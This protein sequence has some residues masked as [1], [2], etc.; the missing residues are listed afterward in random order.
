[1]HERLLEKHHRESGAALQAMVEDAHRRTLALVGGLSEEQLMGPRLPTV[2]P[3]RWE[4]GH[5][6]HFYATFVLRELGDLRPVPPGRDEL[7]DS[8]VVDHED[9]W[10]LALPSTKDTLRYKQEVKSRVLER[11]PG[12]PDPVAT[13]LCL[14]GVQHEDM[15]DEAFLMTRQTLEYPTPALARERDPQAATAG[16]LPGDA[17]VPGGRLVLG[18]APELPFVFDNEKWGHAVE[19]SPFRIA[20]APVTNREFAGFVEDRGYERRELWSYQG[21]RWRTQAGAAHPAYWRRADGGW[22]ARHFDVWRALLPDAPVVH[23]CWYEAEAY[24]RWAGRRLPSELEWEVAAAGE[25]RAAGL[26]SRRRRFPWGDEEPTPERANLDGWWGGLLDVAA[27]PE[28]QS[29]FG[30]R[31]MLGNV[32]EWTASP[33]YPYPGFVVDYPYR[34]YSAPWFGYQKVLRGG[35]WFTRARL[36]RNSFRNFYLPHRRDVLAG[37]RTCAP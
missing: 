9:R 34:E 5:V 2:N 31:Q 17:E 30:C 20:R 1:M 3:L 18:A 24:C 14:L 22:E 33:F 15:H 12:E 25:P 19:V 26:S 16:Q 28:G 13:Y 32:W 29:A 37:F 11:L 23:V 4:V 8:F 21:W 27:L 7:Y 35:A 36:L 10:D 6:A